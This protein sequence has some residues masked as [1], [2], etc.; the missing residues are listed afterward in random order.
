MVSER[1]CL[2]LGRD[3]AD[4][5]QLRID[6]TGETPSVYLRRVIARDC[7]LDAPVLAEGNPNAAAQA[8][9]A[10]DIRWA[11]HRRRIAKKAATVQPKR[12]RGGK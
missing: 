12:K 2:V 10:A 1:I 7:G 3:L 4:A 5:V 11:V 9:R 8:K 6:S